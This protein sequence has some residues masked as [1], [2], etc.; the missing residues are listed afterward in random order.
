VFVLNQANFRILSG[1]AKVTAIARGY[2]ASVAV[3]AYSTV[4]VSLK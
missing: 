4:A 1:T 2:A 3:P